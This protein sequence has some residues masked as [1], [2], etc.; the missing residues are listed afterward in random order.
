[1]TAV[2]VACLTGNRY[3][4]R[5]RRFVLA[6]GG[7]ENARLL[8][9]SN[10]V[11]AS[12]LGNEHDLVGRYFMDHP[13]FDA[14]TITFDGSSA[15]ALA[16]LGSG[17]DAGFG[18]PRAVQEQEKLLN[19]NCHVRPASRDAFDPPGYAALRTLGRGL[20][21]WRLPADWQ[22]LVGDVAADLG[23]AAGGLWQRLFREPGV[24]VAHVYPEVAPQRDSRVLLSTERDALGVPRADLDWRIG[25]IDRRTIV[26]GLERIGAGF[27]RAGL[28]RLRIDEWLLEPGFAL[29]EGS[30]HH[31]GTTRMA[32]DRRQ[33]VVD[34]DCRVH[35][36]RNLFVAGS[37][38]FPTCG[39]APPTM[40]IVGLTLRLADHLAAAGE[41]ENRG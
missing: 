6:T 41:P 7:I 31:I 5:A 1:M 12:G 40:T 20:S 26:R 34:P 2:R 33:G 30:F 37:S 4:V 11:A 8:L 19:F 14:G 36:M 9:A 29:P 25:D 10:A 24:L 22:G 32:E 21:R 35:G 28:G 39:F 13:S 27:A 18:L 23:G 38:V 3:R 15:I 16:P 17:V